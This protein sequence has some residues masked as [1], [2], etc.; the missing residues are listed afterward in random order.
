MSTRTPT[1]STNSIPAYADSE[2][3]RLRIAFVY[4][5]AANAVDHTAEHMATIPGI[6]NHPE[7][8]PTTATE[9]V[10]QFQGIHRALEEH[11]VQL[12]HATP[13]E[14]AFCQAFARDVIMVVSNNING[15]ADETRTRCFRCVMSAKYR[16]DEPKGADE[17]FLRM[18]QDGV[19]DLAQEGP[20]VILE[21]GDVR[22][23]RPGL[24]LVGTGEISN[25]AG[26]N[27]LRKH[28][29]SIGVDVIQV[30]HT[31]L[32]LDCCL[33]PLPNGKAFYNPN[34]LPAGSVELLKP[35]FPHGM[36]QLDPEEASIFLAANMLWIDP[37]TVFSSIT[38]P[39]TNAR[40][41][42]IGFEVIEL[43]VDS[44]NKVWGGIRCAIAE[45]LRDPIE[46]Q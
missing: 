36:E 8:G 27:A 15:E 22:V 4:D 32:H 17:L 29:K 9:F 2:H 25:A 18:S 26:V 28:V 35:H 21:G 30:P 43:N 31:A 45:V 13:V 34:K 19:V 37:K 42:E 39:K 11:G 12:I 7:A 46:K 40:L 14:N 1:E 16:S 23:L 10:D 20:D 41:R 44:P 38:T 6:E 33:A 3:G 24:V 5:G